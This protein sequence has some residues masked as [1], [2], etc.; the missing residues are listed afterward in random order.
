VFRKI[1]QVIRRELSSGLNVRA[2]SMAVAT[3]FTIGIFPI[4]GFSTPLNTLA[5]L[6][7]RLNQPIIQVVNWMMGPLKLL[8]II[9]FLRLGEWLFAAEP[10]S[11]S[12]TE[13]SR[14]FFNDWWGT[15]QEFAWTFVHAI[16]GW[17]VVAPGIYLIVFLLGKAL[18]ARHL[19]AHGKSAEQ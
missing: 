4:M 7:L 6:S 10:F 3:S 17:L 15:T 14:I 11:L 18:L 2:G 13:F 19:V 16:S 9:P 12:L 8:L 1:K 5:A